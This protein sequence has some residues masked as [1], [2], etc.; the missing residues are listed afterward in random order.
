MLEREIIGEIANGWDHENMSRIRIPIYFDYASALCY[1][2][3]R[4][5]TSLED[6]LGFEAL[7][8]GVPVATRDFRARPGRA[9]E[10]HERQK[11]LSVAA[12]TGISVA[13]RPVWIESMPA[14]QGSEIARD[15]GVFPAYHEAVFRAVFE[16]RADIADRKLLDAIAERAGID[17]SK[18]RAALDSRAMFPRIAEHKREADQFSAL[19]YPAFILGDFTM[20]GIQPIETMRLVLGRYIRQRAEEPQ[21]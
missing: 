5:V 3:W 6:E 4:I 8:K 13:P 21:A 17:R 12:E 16:Q 19:G 10:E 14:L 11:V 20:I 7:W 15:A 18:F 1:I 9:L 2:T